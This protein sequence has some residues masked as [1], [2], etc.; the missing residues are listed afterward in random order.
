MRLA[1]LLSAAVVRGFAQLKQS[2]SNTEVN[3][4]LCTQMRV[5]IVASRKL[6]RRGVVVGSWSIARAEVARRLCC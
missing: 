6:A 5:S 3:V 2:R 4:T 1:E